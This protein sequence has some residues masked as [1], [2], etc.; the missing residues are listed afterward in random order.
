MTVSSSH[1]NAIVTN[2]SI[3]WGILSAGKISADFVKAMSITEGA[4]KSIRCRTTGVRLF[5]PK[6]SR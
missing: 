2:K 3:K 1:S 4:G 5:E 6:Q